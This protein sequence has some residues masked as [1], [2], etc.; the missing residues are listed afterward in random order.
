VRVRPSRLDLEAVHE[1][2][3]Q[4]VSPH[5]RQGAEGQAHLQGPRTAGAVS[6]RVSPGPGPHQ[7]LAGLL[8]PRKTPIALRRTRFRGVK[9]TRPS[10]RHTEHEAVLAGAARK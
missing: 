7:H 1:Q 10:P 3:G 9:R 5:P 4:G 2:L 6:S 8:A